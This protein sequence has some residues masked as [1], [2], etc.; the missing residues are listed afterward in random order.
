MH[1][2]KEQLLAA[3]AEHETDTWF[4]ELLTEPKY[5]TCSDSAAQQYSN[6][7][8]ALLKSIKGL[9][10]LPSAKLAWQQNQSNIVVFANGESLQHSDTVL[11][12]VMK[13]CEDW[14]LTGAA[15]DN[16]L[17]S[18]QSVLLLEQLLERGCLEIE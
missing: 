11:P 10:L 4:G 16:A 12:L 1:S 8:G 7:G 17:Q 2:A 5:D 18:S 9:T 13:L 14:Q 6:S 3:L 15:L